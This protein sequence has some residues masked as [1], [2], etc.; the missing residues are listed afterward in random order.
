MLSEAARST[1]RSRVC[2][3]V[4]ACLCRRSKPFTAMASRPFYQ[5]NGFG[6]GVFHLYRTVR[7]VRTK[8]RFA[9]P[10]HQAHPSA[11]IVRPSNLSDSCPGCKSQS[12]VL[13]TNATRKS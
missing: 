3:C 13:V 9:D 8:D 4:C 5:A 11:R 12:P 10:I 6:L 1:L 7:E 2:V